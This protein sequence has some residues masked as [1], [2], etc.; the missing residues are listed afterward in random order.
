[1]RTVLVTGGNRGIGEEV[2]NQFQLKGYRVLATYRN[3]DSNPERI[4][5]LQQKGINFYQLDITD[6][7]ACTALSEKLRCDGIVVDTLVNNAGITADSTFRKMEPEH[8]LKVIDTN[9]IGA[10]NMT[11]VFLTG[12]LEINFGRIINISSINGLKGQFGQCNYS[13]SKAGLIG[14]TKSL[15][16]EV[17]TKGITVNAVSPG[18]VKT[19][20][21]ANMNGSVL[22]AIIG[23][24]P[25]KRM[26][27][28]KEIAHSI[29]FLADEGSS[30]I[31]GENLNVNGAQ[32]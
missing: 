3:S 15:A 19:D 4:K 23:Q 13:A 27:S 20:M 14:F 28:T 21:T 17:A 30:F 6:Y 5:F 31:S 18:Y 1:M 24:I 7:R 9:L 2:C 8:W 12:M 32:F 26:G 29:L 16:L 10:I 25:M 22:D 11:K